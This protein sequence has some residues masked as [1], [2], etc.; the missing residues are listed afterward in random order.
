M[1][2]ERTAEQ[3]ERV[4][5]VYVSANLL[6]M[7]GVAPAALDQGQ[8]LGPAEVPLRC[9]QEG[10]RLGRVDHPGH[11]LDGIRQGGALD[12]GEGQVGG[13]GDDAG[14][15]VVDRRR[16]AA[17]GLHGTAEVLAAVD[18]DGVVD[19]QRRFGALEFIDRR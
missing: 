5:G 2:T 14:E 6:E 4:P 18:L 13:E 3:A 12:G 10:Q 7:L 19:G 11:D 9:G 15:R 17:P 8:R 1:T 16:G